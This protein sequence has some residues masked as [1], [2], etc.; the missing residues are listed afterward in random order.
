M[1][2]TS[3]RPIQAGPLSSVYEA[4]PPETPPRL[5]GGYQAPDRRPNHFLAGN[6]FGVVDDGTRPRLRTPPESVPRF[7]VVPTAVTL[8]SANG[9]AAA[10]AGGD[11][12]FFGRDRGIDVHAA[13]AAV[14]S[15]LDGGAYPASPEEAF[16]AAVERRS[17]AHLRSF[18]TSPEVLRILDDDDDNV[19]NGG[20]VGLA[21]AD[22][23]RGGRVSL[24]AP[25]S[26][27]LDRAPAPATAAPSS[28]WL[29]PRSVPADYAPPEGASLARPK[30]SL[31]GSGT[32]SPNP[33]GWK[34]WVDTVL[35]VWKVV[36]MVE[37]I[38]A[39]EVCGLV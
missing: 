13:E 29:E 24:P 16:E 14:L 21:P 2:A 8:S 5:G 30:D 34:L 17:K 32:W 20:G 28:A 35:V 37:R 9:A 33:A 27:A 36:G 31:D 12:R 26:E 18:L 6:L 4:A 15:K 7:A 1:L 10:R 23:Q 39:A 22:S 19:G 38:P 25:R 3:T 11:P